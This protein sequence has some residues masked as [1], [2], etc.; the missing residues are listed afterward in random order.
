MPLSHP[1]LEPYEPSDSDPFD[2]VKAAHLLNRAGFGGTLE[3][4]EHIRS[5]GPQAAVDE[6]LDF[7]DAPAEEESQND[8]P[9]LSAIDGLPKTL[10]EAF[11]QL[12]TRSEEEKRALR[13]KINMANNEVLMAMAH[14]WMKRMVGGPY[15]LQEK[16]TLFW[17]G[18]FTTSAKDE[19]TSALLWR[20]NE[21][22]RRMAAGNFGACDQ[23][24]SGNAG[25][26]Q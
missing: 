17:H 20:Q 5:L 10:R 21:L 22:Q 8:V 6:L 9:D 7:P 1:M 18:H 15:P 13:M 11:M 26:P 25:L 3:E 16:L 23:P 4:I 19:H 2:S 14:W 24:R 12:R